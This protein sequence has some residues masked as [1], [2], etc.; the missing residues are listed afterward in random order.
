MTKGAKGDWL[1]AT[2]VGDS[3]FMHIRVAMRLKLIT[4]E[5]SLSYEAKWKREVEDL[6]KR[7]EAYNDFIIKGERYQFNLTGLGW[8]NCDRFYKYSKSQLV[9]YTVQTTDSL[10]VYPY[11]LPMVVFKKDNAVLRGYA[12]KNG[13]VVFGKIPKNE[14]VTL[15]LVGVRDGKI[16]TCIQELTTTRKGAQELKFSETSPEAFSKQLKRLG[17]VWNRS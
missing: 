17:T 6:I 2:T 15:V 16:F 9:N 1:T 5:D 13:K 11:M 14:D 12:D 4:R 8:I 7:N 10:S 3:V